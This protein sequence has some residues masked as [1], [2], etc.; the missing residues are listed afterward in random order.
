VYLKA[1]NDMSTK[2]EQ[3]VNAALRLFYQR[4]FNATG[5]DAVI[6]EARVSKKTLYN[7]FRTK[8]ELILATLRKRDE[9]FR[10]NLMRETE[11][12]AS[13]PIARL[14]ALFDTIGD[15]FREKSFSGCMF[16][17][18]AAEFSDH[19][20]PS[21]QLAA[22]HKKLV[23]DYIEGIAEEA[24]AADPKA[25]AYELN[26]LIEGAIV[27]AHVMGDKDAARRAKEMAQVH[28]SRQL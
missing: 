3:I 13:T 11:R 15:W 27:Y 26:L 2:R 16:I 22:Q 1:A 20:N 24:G 17:N 4:G 21:H 23:C 7:H 9:L 18:A 28:I 10:N 6:A 12:K 5:V 25:L 19:D 14:S 8:D